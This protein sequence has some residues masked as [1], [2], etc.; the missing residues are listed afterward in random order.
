VVGVCEAGIAETVAEVL[1]ANGAE[2]AIVVHGAD[3]LDEF[4]TTG[5]STVIQVEP[6]SVKQYEVSP[7]E[8]G[9]Q[10]ATTDDLRG[11]DSEENARLGRQI[12]DGERGPRRDLVLLNAAAG[13]VVAGLAGD[14]AD[15]LSR[16]EKAVDDGSAGRVLEDLVRVSRREETAHAGGAAQAPAGQR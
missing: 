16:A 14:L 1:Q 13:I 5:T 11:G 9:L 7:G 2:R 10:Q 8:L 3:G 4:T 6:D 15:G 12:L